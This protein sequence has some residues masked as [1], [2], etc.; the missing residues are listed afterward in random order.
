MLA[1]EAVV[2]IWNGVAEEGW[3]LNYA[4]HLTEH[5]PERVGIPGFN[6]GRRF[7]AADG[8]T[9]PALFTLYEC[10]TM[11]VLQGQDYT[12]R[13]NAP[14]PW[15]REA[16]KFARDT[17]RGLARVVASHGPGVGGMMLTLRFDAPA[18]AQAPVAT[19]LREAAAAAPRVTGAHLCIADPAASGVVTEE[20]RGRSDIGAPPAWFILLEATDAEALAGLLP[21]AALTAAGAMGPY[22]RGL[23][24]LEYLRTKTAWAP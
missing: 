11:Q 12:N 3:A 17:S 19:L 18:T 21:D 1:G 4:W 6:R 10:D 22:R 14:T 5:M 2:A 8:A 20:K 15:T 24:R 9:H 13:L 23:Y 16:G 7:R